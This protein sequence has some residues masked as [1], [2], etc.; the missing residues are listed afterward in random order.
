MAAAGARPWEG[1]G[2]LLRG[3]EVCPELCGSGGAW[4]LGQRP[5][6]AAEATAWSR[7]RLRGNDPPRWP[8]P[9]PE[10]WHGQGEASVPGSV[11]GSGTGTVL[12]LA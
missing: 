2:S 11:G 8:L 1:V 4:G 12:S 6:G 10:R 9:R 7:Q 3:G 5:P